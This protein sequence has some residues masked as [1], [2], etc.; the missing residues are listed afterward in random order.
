MDQQVVRMVSE[1]ATCGHGLDSASRI[2]QFVSEREMGSGPV[3]RLIYSFTVR[4]LANLSRRTKI[5]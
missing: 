3:A 5:G 2:W 4:R 1:K